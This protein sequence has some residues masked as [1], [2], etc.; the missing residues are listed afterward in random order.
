MCED[1]EH[2]KGDPLTMNLFLIAVLI[3]LVAEYVLDLIVERLNV[4]HASPEI[5]AE[6][7]DVYDADKYAKSQAYLKENTRVDL[8]KSTIM[9]P[10]TLVFILVGGFGWIDRLCRGAGQPMIVTG[11]LFFGVLMLL[12]LIVGLPFDIHDT[13]VLEAKYGFNKTTPKTFVL[14]RL[15]GVLLSLLIGAPVGAM[16]LWFF[17]AMPQWGWLVAWGALGIVQIALAWIAP[18]VILP[19]FNTFTPLEEGAL[20]DAIEAYAARQ[21]VAVKG[22]FSIDG[23]RRSTKSNAYF[24]GFGK[25]KRIALFD[26]LIE[27]HTVPELVGVL[28]HEVGHDRCGHVRKG[29]ALSLVS[30]LLTLFLLQ[31]FLTQPGLYAAFGVEY[32]PI[33]SQ[34][35]IYAGMAFFGFLYAPLSMVV[36]IVGSLLSRRWEFQA[37]AFAKETTGGSAGMIA[38][39]KKLSVENLS[40]LTPHPLYVF[41][42]YSHPPVLARIRALKG[43][44]RGNRSRL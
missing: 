11:L 6:F 31:L 32:A 15:K 40:N 4:Q 17:A 36:G 9:L 29:I 18:V 21:D 19:L 12:G 5:P 30:S 41:L 43:E 39:L 35:P 20:R 34:L 26:T 44:G 7:T 24:T 25:S 14:D 27:N 37:D 1:G 23:S 33:G 10:V 3:I 28:A 2:L 42:H 16:V 22:I 13:F 8:L 38:A